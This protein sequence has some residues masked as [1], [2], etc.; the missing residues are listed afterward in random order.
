MR[1]INLHLLTYLLTA[2][3]VSFRAQL[4]MKRFL[5]VCVSVY[6]DGKAMRFSA[7]V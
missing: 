7:A 4:E 1:Y 5:S 6:V 2:N 3:P